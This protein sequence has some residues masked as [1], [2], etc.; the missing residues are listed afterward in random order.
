MAQ[1]SKLPRGITL[2]RGRY[3][4]R[5]THEGRTHALGMFETLTDARAALEIARGDAARGRFVSPVERRRARALDEAKAEAASLT[6]SDWAETWLAKLE[7]DP[8]RSL[9]TVVSY[10]SVLKNHVLPDLGEIRLVEL[11]KDRVADHLA[12]L[13]RRPSGRHPGAR[14]NGV[15][16]NVVIVL[17]SMINAAVKVQAG[18]LERFDFPAAPKHR[19]VRPEDE[20]GDVVSSEEVRALAEAMPSHLQIAVPLAAWCALRIG[21]LLGLQRRDLEEL[22]DPRRAVLHVR[23]Q[24]NVK[25]NAL[26]PPKADSRRSIAVPHALLPALRHHL[27]T[28]TGVEPT[29]PVLSG[30][31]GSR[32]SQSA[33][34]RAWRAAREQAG[35]PEF[36]FHN[37][38]HTGLSKYAE[39]GATLAELLHRGG[40]TDVTVAL[41]YQHATAERDRALTERLSSEIG[42][43][44]NELR[45][46]DA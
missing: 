15:A 5:M 10:R 11:S 1:P 45:H 29:A 8:H 7:A 40:H 41:R 33:L 13:A 22:D 16:P 4:V 19:R 17:R 34:D 42:H 18:G 27:E 24:W 32:V 2:Y 20:R 3:R 30:A 37:L 25:A 26:T 12:T 36:R 6:V 28:Y 43:P 21:E 35:R 46:I 23:R 39:Q 38:R 14:V 44:P 31:R 9:A